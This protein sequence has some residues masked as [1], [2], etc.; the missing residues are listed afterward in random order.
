MAWSQV[1]PQLHPDLLRGLAQD[2][3]MRVSMGKVEI[4]D[5]NDLG[6]GVAP[7]E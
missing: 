7:P 4:I 2:I 5:V 6:V 1:A 3:L